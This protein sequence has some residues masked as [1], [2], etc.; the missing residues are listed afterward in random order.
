M[1]QTVPQ[2]RFLGGWRRWL[3]LLFALGLVV[4][5]SIAFFLWRLATV[6]VDCRQQTPL[7]Q[8]LRLIAPHAQVPEA[9]AG[10][11]GPWSGVWRP[12]GL[13]AVSLLFRNLMR[14][15]G[16]VP[17]CQ[18]LVVEEIYANGYARITFSYAASAAFDVPLPE[19]SR[20]TGRVVNGTLQFQLPIPGAYPSFTYRLVDGE[21][22]GVIK[23]AGN[24]IPGFR[25]LRV[26]DLDQ[27]GCDRGTA[28]RLAT[29]PTDRPRTHLTAADL[30]QGVSAQPGLVHNAYFLPVGQQASARH[31]LKGTLKV[32]RS[33][34]L[35]SRHGCPGLVETLPE[36]T[37]AFFTHGDS[38]VP[39]LRDLL[40][41]PGNLILSP[42][43]VWSEPDDLG[44]S[45]ASFPF[46]LTS[47]ASNETHNGLATFLYDDT[48]VSALQFQFVQETAAWAKYDGWGRAAMSYAPGPI[49]G[50]ELLRE[51]FVTEVQKQSPVQPWS[52]LPIPE[53]HQHDLFTGGAAPEDVSVSGM[54]VD[55]TV[56]LH[57]CQTRSGP[58]PYCQQ[59]RHGVFSVTKSLGAAI[60]LLRLAQKY[61]EQVFTLKIKEYLQVAAPH[62]GWEQVTFSDALN[63]ATGIGDFAPQREPNEPF[64]D[65]NKPKTFQWSIAP[66][67]KEKLAISFSYGKYAWGP[68]QVYRY[69]STQTFVLAAAMD[70]FLKQKEGPQAHLW[71]MVAKEVLHPIGI[72][73]LPTMHT[74]EPQGAPGIPL[75]ASGLYPTLDDIAK[76]TTLLQNG[77]RYQDQQI[78]HPGKL[79]EAMNKT[80]VKGLPNRFENRFGEGQYHLSFWS[81][82][83]RTTNGCSFQIPYMTGYGGNFVMLLPSGVSTFRFADGHNYEVD[84]MIVM[85]EAIRPFPCASA[86]LESRS[87]GVLLNGDEVRTAFAGNTLY[88]DGWRVG[89]TDARLNMFIAP[90]GMRYVTLDGGAEIGVWPDAGTWR[91]TPDG[92]FCSKGWTDRRER[93]AKVYQEGETFELYPTDGFEK[94]TFRRVSGNPEG[95]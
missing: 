56:Y 48:R 32:Q 89:T 50:E 88:A 83:Y 26:A 60:A 82:P 55:G 39:V 73:H 24:E 11:A 87:R 78:L 10:F 90:D 4:T 45:R 7:P 19:V 57:S 52:A 8:D 36:F 3:R 66:T 12:Q 21:L 31:A 6:P 64:A 27:W 92:Q 9:I 63:M 62:D 15:Q 85:G 40:Q 30:M 25:L 41:P 33:T 65:E 77:G 80:E 37:M 23:L 59:M 1:T 5:V 54:V 51:Q 75:L 42:G 79:A 44:M 38:L 2:R 93:C 84:T 95:Y 58:Y 61:G 91:I 69:N 28:D 86:A 46:I 18:T 72:V 74:I 34:I 68:G 49:A 70:S 14:G 47:M 43:R 67:A 16:V 35:K 94:W 71:D 13:V 53:P 17:S 29:P 76:L 22:E 81:L 20:T